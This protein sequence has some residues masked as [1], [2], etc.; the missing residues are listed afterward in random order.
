MGLNLS[1]GHHEIVLKFQVPYLTNGIIVS[2]VSLCLTLT[3]FVIL[4]KIKAK[5]S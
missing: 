1:E 2:L 3:L 5:D 4:K